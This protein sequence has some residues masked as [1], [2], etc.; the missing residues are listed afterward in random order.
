MHWTTKPLDQGPAATD[1][2]DEALLLGEIRSAFGG[3]QGAR[4]RLGARL[5]HMLPPMIQR[6]QHHM[7]PPGV[8]REV[9]D[10]LQG[11]LIE[12]FRREGYILRQIDPARGTAR[13]FLYRVLGRWLCRRRSPPVTQAL[14]DDQ[15]PEHERDFG[16][17]IERMLCL[18]KVMVGLERS[19]SER[20]G[21]LFRRIFVEE[22][23]IKVVA[24]E[25][26][27]TI[28]AVHQWC[29]RTRQ[30]AEAIARKVGCRREDT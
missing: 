28:D 15:E 18:E 13:A 2:P 14:H 6:L 25:M 8:D 24:A 4:R 7:G 21:R 27:M 19:F 29:T 9:E 12:L 30:R 5:L 1:P 20:D 11:F 22:A 16:E 3:D 17:E 26:Q 23:E 10:L